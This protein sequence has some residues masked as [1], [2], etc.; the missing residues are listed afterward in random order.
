MVIG[1]NIDNRRFLADSSPEWRSLERQGRRGAFREGSPHGRI[2]LRGNPSQQGHPESTCN[3][4]GQ[5]S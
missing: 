4:K 5:A 1:K 3:T 2:L